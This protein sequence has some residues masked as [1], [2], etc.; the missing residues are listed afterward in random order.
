MLLNPKRRYIMNWRGL[1]SIW[2]LVI[3]I[4]AMA[5]I[6]CGTAEAQQFTLSEYYPLKQGITWIY[7]TTY[8]DGHRDYETFCVGGAETFDGTIA[9]KR[10]EFDSGELDF[11]DHYYSAEAWTRKG[12]RVFKTAQSEGEYSLFSPPAI[13]RP[14]TM[15]VGQM[16]QHSSTQTWYDAAGNVTGTDDFSIEI[17]LL[18]VENVTVRGRLFPKCLK[19]SERRYD[20]GLWFEGTFWLARGVGMVKSVYVAVGIEEIIT[21]ELIAYTKG[22]KTRYPLE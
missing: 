4:F 15:R 14:A 21:G 16:F 12:L 10:W 19:F 7:L 22:D 6:T 3:A 2:V 1:N 13:M 20:E 17:T 11:Y 9:K 18:G 8:A 5:V